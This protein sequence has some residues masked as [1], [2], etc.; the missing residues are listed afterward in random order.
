MIR[1]TTFFYA[2]DD[3]LATVERALADLYYE[4]TRERYPLDTAELIRIWH[5]ALTAV[6]L[7]FPK[8]LR[9]TGLRRFRSEIEWVLWMF[10]DRS[11]E[12]NSFAGFLA[13]T[14]RC[15]DGAEPPYLQFE[16]YVPDEP[17]AIEALNSYTTLAPSSLGQKWQLED[18]LFF[19]L[20]AYSPIPTASSLKHPGQH[21]NFEIR[22]VVDNHFPF[23]I[24]Q[25]V[26]PSG[27]L[28][29]CPAP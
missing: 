27:V 9:Y 5:S 23:H 8:M 18:G 29:Q 25:A 3:G 16:P 19:N 24:V 4:V 2:V 17:A 28:D 7:E 15:V 12:T 14:R 10:K 13:L 1:K 26:Q 11:Q 20:I 22:V 6:S 21:R